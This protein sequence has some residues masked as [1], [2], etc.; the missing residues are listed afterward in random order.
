MRRSL[1]KKQ[2]RSLLNKNTA[3]RNLIE[4]LERRELLSG[5][6]YFVDASAVGANTGSSWANAY[7]SLQSAITAAV[8]GDRINVADGTYK[9]SAGTGRTATFTLKSG[10][11]MYGGYAGYGATNPDA[12]DV[13]AYPTIL[14]GDIGSIG[15]S[16]DNS[17]HVIIASGTTA[18]TVLD[19]LTVANGNANGSS[20]RDTGAGIYNGGGNPTISNC[21]FVSNLANFAGAGIYN[22]ASA[23]PLIS[24]CM[25]RE[26]FANGTQIDEGGGAAIYNTSASATVKNCVF[27]ANRGG[28]S[29]GAVADVS[30]SSGTFT[31]CYFLGNTGSQWGSAFRESYSNTKVTN[32]VF[33]GNTATKYGGAI[34]NTG[35]VAVYTNCSFVN[36]TADYSGAS[37]NNSYSAKANFNNCIM[38][39]SV[40]TTQNSSMFNAILTITYSDI[41]GGYSGAGN[42]NAD[43]KFVRVPS[44]GTD[45]IW[46]TSDDDYGDLSLQL[47]SP[48]IDAG[49][50]TLVPSGITTDMF[51]RS[52][53]V[54]VPTRTDTGSGTAPIVDMGIYEAGSLV[55]ANPG[56]PYSIKEGQSVTLTASG[57]SNVPGPLTYAWEWS[58]DGKFDDAV[59]TNPVFNSQGLAAGNVTVLLRVTD[60]ASMSSIASTV[61]TI[62]PAVLYVDAKAVGANNG[63]SWAN[64]YTSLASALNASKPGQEVRVAEGTYKPTTTTDRS[65][66]FLINNLSALKGG[67][68]GFGAANPD[69][70]NPDLY[71]TILSG[72]IGVAGDASDNSRNV[73]TISSSGSS[74]L[75]D[76]FT[77]TAGNANAA[78]PPWGVSPSN[79]GGGLY[80]AGSPTIQN[81][82][83]TANSA[84]ACG[85]AILNLSTAAPT[86]NNCQFIGNNAGMAGGAI[87]GSGKSFVLKG[88]LFLENSSG[89]IG[90]AVHNIMSSNITGCT[91][92]RNHT[93]VSRDGRGGAIFNDGGGAPCF[94]NCFF[95]GN[96]TN[97][98]K[99]YSSG[100]A[101]Y[102][103]NTDVTLVNCVMVGNTTTGS[104]G[105]LY[106]NEATLVNCTITNN[107]AKWGGGIC[108][109]LYRLTN[110]IIWGNVA[111]TY[112]QIDTQW[113]IQ[114]YRYN[115]VLGVVAPGQG[116]VSKYPGFARDPNKGADGVWGTSD[117]DYGNL[118]LK[119]LSPLIDAG[120]NS[121]VPSGIIND[122][123]GK[124][125]F[126]DYPMTPDTGSGAPPIVDMGAYEAW[127]PNPT[128]SMQAICD[129][130]ISDSDR[131]T[132]FDGS[133]NLPLIFDVSNTLPGATVT[134]YVD[135][136]PL[137]S[138]M[139]ENDHLVLVTDGSSPLAD[140]V[141]SLTVRMMLPDQT[142]GYESAPLSLT[143]DTSAPAAVKPDLQASSDTGDNDSDNVT[144]DNTPT[145]DI[146]AP[147]YTL[148]RNGVLVAGP[149]ASGP[150]TS[151]E[152]GNG[153]WV[154]TAVAM[155][156]AGNLSTQVGKLV[157]RID[158][159]QPSSRVLPLTPVNS[160][161]EILVNW[162]GSDN[163]GGSG[164]ASYD[165][166]V[167]ENENEPTLWLNQTHATSG[168][169]VGQFGHFYRFLSVARDLAGNVEPL[170]ASP[171]AVTLIISTWKGTPE[172]DSLTLK[173]DGSGS[174][175]E[176]FNT[177]LTPDS[178]PEFS[179]PLSL[180]GSF[181][182]DGAGG[183]DTLFVDFTNGNPLS[184]GGLT[185][186]GS[187]NLNITASPGDDAVTL[188]G[189]HVTINDLQLPLENVQ[190]ISLKTGE[191][192]DVVNIES[193]FAKEFQLQ[194]GP[195]AKTLN[196]QGGSRSFPSDLGAVAEEAAEVK[197]TMNLT[198]GA[199]AAFGSTQHL[200]AL[201]IG[202]NTT[203]KFNPGVSA[204]LFADG[205][206]IAGA[207]A[208]LGKLDLADSDLVLHYAGIAPYS[209]VRPW[210]L[211]GIVAGRGIFSSTGSLSNPNVIGI[212]DNA[213]LHKKTWGALTISDGSD[214]NQLVTR[215]TRM[216]DVN[217]DGKVDETDEMIILANLNKSGAT[218]FEGDINYTSYVTLDDLAIVQANMGANLDLV[219][220]KQTQTP[221]KA[222]PSAITTAA[223]P[224]KT[225]IS[226]KKII[227][228]KKVPKNR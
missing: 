206:T 153:I 193:A 7:T 181:D 88:C 228:H 134:V 86:L 140:G 219:S 183:V 31:N 10:V 65:A 208:T 67:Y 39:N 218:Y 5:A 195:G 168:T 170:R 124:S 84:S 87:A 54:D 227:K 182:I 222:S 95:Y 172:N 40:V 119:Y 160:S 29:G 69:A 11:A 76:G 43:P 38:W 138:A 35:G 175:V 91:F 179:I 45:N 123:S 192:T 226:H 97:P 147:Y 191:G 8:S 78:M 197:V 85:A 3:I 94:A 105:A 103:N 90:G 114:V 58:G 64:A 14:S 6:T 82:I 156:A 32:C 12:R 80:N 50:N 15:N 62:Y 79:S 81:C 161:D 144:S 184:A 126:Y 209:S 145:L 214:Y 2:R 121:G 165:V 19:G 120:D 55:V 212:A 149:N 174:S 115:D 26:N 171:G 204:G 205:L 122:I 125:R 113:E 1:G 75:I 155:D 128:L 18:T 190:S 203:A 70:R 146:D 148:Y 20:S 176:F 23:R 159:L 189:D 200:A 17:Y 127:I 4:T 112:S 96:Y 158:T 152:L 215:R 188:A 71:T 166:Y 66:T 217:L 221:T 187:F 102:A 9:P 169:F 100:G 28:Y 74:P 42:L 22:S 47:T 194:F 199:T 225:K 216:G 196:L 52:R 110:N 136:K 72:D 139:A 106:S 13:A 27:V 44:A 89:E 141:H 162:S 49:N 143:I 186:V 180:M 24:D 164:I 99:E 34:D 21:S 202:E 154:F 77:I 30:S 213:R 173:L 185:L 56:G 108:S 224:K 41:Q 59:G 107:A 73:I 92:I 93:A 178:T 16:T 131:V 223:T 201:N 210:I 25:F 117:D 220:L 198:D 33:V 177:V 68:A 129:S 116:N 104:G 130:G 133:E 163:V 167:S 36:N 51:G 46:G 151:P 101:I 132:F 137:I 63:T 142:V 109:F 118:S 150:Y 211:S 135:D 207:G 111:Q 37:T 83:F 48:A 53:F 57:A 61:I 157:V 60:S 98:E